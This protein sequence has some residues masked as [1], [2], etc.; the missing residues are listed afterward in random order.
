MIVHKHVRDYQVPE[1]DN[2]SKRIEKDATTLFRS[3]G[4]VTLMTSQKITG[5]RRD[6]GKRWY[7]WQNMSAMGF[8]R[9]SNG[10]ILAYNV[11]RGA[12]G[13]ANGQVSTTFSLF[14]PNG[15]F[16]R[17]ME[18][19]R[20]LV[21]ATIREEF[22]DLSLHSLYPIAAMY[23]IDNYDQIPKALLPAFRESD[24]KDFV[25]RTFGKSRVR[26]DLVKS[27]AEAHPLQI[28]VIQEFRGLVPVDWI[29]DNLR[30]GENI[31]PVNFRPRLRP[32]LKQIDPHSY[33]ALLRDQFNTTSIYNVRELS[34][35]GRPITRGEGQRVRNWGEF[36]DVFLPPVR[37]ARGGYIGNAGAGRVVGT[38]TPPPP[39]VNEPIELTDLAKS[40]HEKVEGE[41]KITCATETDQMRAWSNEM[42]NCI[43]SYA[44]TAKAGRGIYGAVH[45]GEKLLANFEVSKTYAQTGPQT[46]KYTL[47]QLLG[48]ANSNLKEDD[49]VAIEKMLASA[50]V[51]IPEHYWG[52]PPRPRRNGFGEGWQDLGFVVDH[53]P[54]N[55]GHVPA[56]PV[57]RAE[58]IR[59]ERINPAVVEAP[60]MNELIVEG[61]LDLMGI[62]NRLDNNDFW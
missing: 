32:L 47:K 30:S 19:L 29:V 24:F 37:L 54:D 55:D 40:L 4:K 12:N 38:Y 22:G 49:R 43:G 57:I 23:D 25:A 2:G 3:P 31:H 33:R 42:S 59:V 27:A 36:H 53:E 62:N 48:K 44:S 11:Y 35:P 41:Y 51:T 9:N 10:T 46:E 8:R 6:N 60:R 5:V 45:R 15:Y 56:R 21:P 39:P 18:G 7:R 26:K 52:G 13:W 58:R 28:G 17:Y 50:G 20:E 14:D 1:W 34:L 16:L 61:E